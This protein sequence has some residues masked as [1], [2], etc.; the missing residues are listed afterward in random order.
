MELASR[1]ERNLTQNCLNAGK[2]LTYADQWTK[3]RIDQR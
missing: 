2:D 3:D 1:F